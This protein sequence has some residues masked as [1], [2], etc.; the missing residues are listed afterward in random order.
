MFIILPTQLFK[1]IKLLKNKEIYLIEEP[2]YFTRLN[3]HKLKIAYHRATMKKYYDYLLKKNYKIKYIDFS[4]VTDFYQKIKNDN[5]E[6]YH[7]VDYEIVNK[8]INKF[9]NLTIHP[10]LN[11]TFNH[12]QIDEYKEQ[13]F[14]NNKFYHDDFYKYQRLKLDIL[15]KNNKPVDG[16]WSFDVQNRK[17]FSTKINPPSLLNIRLNHYMEEAIAYTNKHFKQNYGSLEHF[18]YPISFEDSKKWLFDFLKNK[19]LHFGDFQDAVA[20]DKPFGFHSI[21]SPMMNI[22]LITDTEVINI[23]YQYYLKNKNIIS[24]NNFEAFIRQV[25]GW[26]NYVYLIYLIKGPELKNQNFLDHQKQLTKKY[27]LQLWE[28]TTPIPVIND[29]IQKIVKYGYSH[30]IERLMYLGNYL[31]INLFHPNVAYQLF[32]EW[33]VDSYDWVMV[34]NVYAMSQFADGGQ[35]M[36]RIYFSSSN[37][38]TKMSNYKKNKNTEWDKIWDALYYNF[39][40]LHQHILRKNYATSRQV[41][42]WNKKTKKEQNELIKIANKYL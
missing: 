30:H 13:C 41:I 7:P 2:Y 16:K 14:R 29:I 38:I 6:I 5:I 37:Y 8:F 1:N 34:P 33:T 36:T 15:V 23:S 35:M 42:H 3:F 11:F 40:N 31:L 9:K 20:N 12:L 4:K 39:I 24:I 22:G 25:I 19:L 27:Y 10:T 26:R 32:M 28:G 18:I 21:L 17:P